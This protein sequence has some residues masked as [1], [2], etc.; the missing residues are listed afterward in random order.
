MTATRWILRGL[1][2]FRG[3]YAGVVAGCALAA[4]VLLGALIAGDSMEETLRRAA[5]AR[6]GKTDAALDGGGRWFR[7]ALADELVADG[8]VA[9]PVL[10]LRG[11]VTVADGGRALGGVQVL[12]VDSR[13]FQLAP[14]EGATAPVG[15][16][17]HINSL[18]A[19]RLLVGTG[20]TLVL[21]FA[22]PG[23]GMA[24]VPMAGPAPEPTVLRGEVAAVLDERRFGRFGLENS[25]LGQPTV[26]VPLERLQA[27]AEQPAMINLLLL[28]TPEGAATSVLTDAVRSHCTLAD[29][30]IE[31][32]R[33]KLANS[34]ELR[35]KRVFFDRPLATAIQKTF[36]TSRPVIT[37]MANGISARGLT[38]PYSMVT[39]VDP[40]SVAFLPPALT[41]VAVNSWLADD[42]GL[43]PDD[44]IRLDYYAVDE[45]NRLV[46]RSAELT[47]SAVVPME[48][49]AADP[50]WMPEF[51]GIASAESTSDW[52][53]GVPID[54]KRIRDK[55][56]AYWD[57][58][59]GTP[60]LFLPL[61][62]GRELFGNRWGD[63]TAIRIQDADPAKTTAVLLESLT[64]ADAGLFVRDV[65][66]QALA[67]ASSPVD[68]AGLLLGMSLFL[69]AAAVA[70]AAMLFRFHIE[71]RNRESALLAT[72]GVAPARVL[73]WRLGE[74]LGVV[75]LGG[76]LG[77]GLALGY[78]WF[79]LGS[80][81]EIWTP[82]GGRPVLWV[83][84]LTVTIGLTLFA[85]L[86][87]A[88]IWLV[89]RKQV[90]QSVAIRL[91][92]AAEEATPRGVVGRPWG[93]A[94]LAAAGVL[95]AAGSPVLGTKGAFF[96][97][98]CC[99]LAAGLA[100]L[101]R[102]L[103]AKPHA[104]P[105]DSPADPTPQWLA[106]LNCSRRPVRSLVVA[107]TLSAGV[108]MLV[109]VAAFCKG[110]E[111]WTR[112]DGPTGGYAL[113]AET[114]LPGGRPNNP[115]A[116]PAGLGDAR[117]R[118][119]EILAVREGP[120]DDASC[121]NLN[122]VARPRLLAVDSAALARRGAFSIK[123]TL[124]GLPRS[125]EALRGGDIMRAFV[126][127][128][129]LL[130]VLKK[131]P[132]DR[133][134]YQDDAGRDYPVEIA[135]TLEGSVFQ[136]AFIV[137]EARF[138][139]HHP[140][141]GGP[142]I[143]LLDAAEPLDGARAILRHALGDR[144]VMADTTASR[145]SAFHGVENAYIGVFHL[146]GGL[147]VILGSAGLGVLT[148]RNLAERKQEFAILHTMGIPADVIRR[149]ALSEA[150]MLT[151]WGLALGLGAAFVAI[152][153]GLGFGG[154]LRALGWIALLGGLVAL[155]G[156]F[157]SWLACRKYFRASFTTLADRG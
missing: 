23:T 22:K 24:D 44:S 64:P 61:G 46:E 142:R 131:K 87:M 27:A 34:V 39:A 90:R 71:Q 150:A 6:L 91:E 85:G 134:I 138:L 141:A 74:G 133:I 48:G 77:I 146:L 108:F 106:A 144:G 26:F 107:G 19:D 3:S 157:W 66:D 49:P 10:R 73:W 65:R 92:T 8:L 4:M 37:Y 122:Q 30:G 95:A 33:L 155:N 53:A 143:F 76:A 93:V 15:G 118:F 62:I 28:H 29:Y 35:T 69:M 132:G 125:W 40:Q 16:A 54:L 9:A 5:L 67:A 136:G 129:T 120:G 137:D 50:K 21:R 25:Q 17:I 115:T 109:S 78:T 94:S 127:E 56:E 7:A 68:F 57:E 101:R 43:K 149:I 41:G 153:P 97:T 20:E 119:G 14:E 75:A 117:H 154:A 135:G 32:E 116:D 1:W 145:M 124:D 12:G 139:K 148:A 45:T 121:L 55:D 82:D 84:G 13:F 83:D 88:T 89:A 126:D 63:A 36:P 72:L 42:L 52:D 2:H 59:R 156:W 110:D 60:K 99:L 98:G 96:L 128:S 152:L 81:A 18:L 51:P 151:R 80:L 103:L 140:Q 31:I 111:D 11:E 114:T 105:S 113:W 147:G 100:G 38:T 58:H 102:S 70:L 47:V 112:R 104:A 86:M 123:R 79:L 130:W